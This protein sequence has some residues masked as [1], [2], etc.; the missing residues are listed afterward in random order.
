MI[1]GNLL[2]GNKGNMAEGNEME[3]EIERERTEI[4]HETDLSME[5][6]ACAEV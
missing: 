2:L 1:K 3:N 4:I 5:V 6:P